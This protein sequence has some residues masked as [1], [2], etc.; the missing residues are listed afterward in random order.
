MQWLAMFAS[1]IV[2]RLNAKARGLRETAEE[3]F[4]EVS[5]KSRKVVSLTLTGLCAVILFC[6]GFFISL[7]DS[8]TQYDRTGGIAWTATLSAG[9]GLIAVAAITFAYVFLRAW[10]GA[11]HVH[12]QTH[13]RRFETPRPS[14]SLENALATLVM[15]FV[16]ERETRRTARERRQAAT[17]P[18]GER[19]WRREKRAERADKESPSSPLH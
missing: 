1:F 18:G 6:G 19:F 9:I 10:P 16:R 11:R 15:D 4:D 5:R 12:H 2:G 13:H 3:V 17:P 14:S 8:T 7:L